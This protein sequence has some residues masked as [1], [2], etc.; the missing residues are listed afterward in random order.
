MISEDEVKAI[1]TEHGVP[2]SQIEKDYVIGWLLWGISKNRALSNQLVL[3]GG[4]CLR[5]LYYPETRFSDDL[6]FTAKTKFGTGQFKNH[7][8]GLCGQVRERSGLEFDLEQTKVKVTPI[9]HEGLHAIDGRVYFRGFAGDSSITMRIKFDVS[10]YEKIVLPL[11]THPL[12]HGYSDADL[13]STDVLAYSLEEVLAEKLRSWIQRTR[14]R[15]LFDMATIIKSGAIPINHG[16]IMNAFLQKTVYKNIPTAN[17]EEL[18]YEEKFE[19]IENSWDSTIICPRDSRII[20]KNAVDL[21][22]DFVETLFSKKTIGLFKGASPQ[23]GFGHYDYRSGIRESIISAGK[24][25]RLIRMRYRGIDRDIEPYSFRYRLTK[26]GY[27]GEYFY[28]FDRTRGDTIKSFLLP[29]VEKVSI[30]P[31]IYSPRWLVEF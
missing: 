6:D 28:G 27:G 1:A 20:A 2:I 10:E 22:S 31:Q 18:L 14:P 12:I 24:A 21:F 4:N 8:N 23:T 26:G 19:V 17:Q 13:C 15:D 16:Q 5:K 7:L 25:Q 9:S 29:K 3:K 30:L 11:Q